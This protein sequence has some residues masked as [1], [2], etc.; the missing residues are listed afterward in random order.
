ML[1]TTDILVVSDYL[2][3]LIGGAKQVVVF[4]LTTKVLDWY[5]RLV[6][7]GESIKQVCV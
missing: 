6:N 3:A 4:S 1:G 7:A 2:L 5:S